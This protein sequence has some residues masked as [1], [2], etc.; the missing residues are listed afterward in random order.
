MIGFYLSLIVISIFIVQKVYVVVFVIA[1]FVLLVSGVR[2]V[3]KQA[4]LIAGVLFFL[5]M[6]SSIVYMLNEDHSELTQLV[7]V[8]VSLAFLPF[9]IGLI[10]DERIE[11]RVYVD[12]LY[13]VLVFALLVNAAH[14]FYNVGKADVW[15]LPFGGEM[16]SSSAY[17]IQ[18]VGI[19][20]GAPN[21]NI[22]ATKFL[23]VFI[24]YI[25]MFV[26]GLR[27]VKAVDVFLFFLFS[28]AVIYGMSRTSQLAYFSFIALLVFD[29]VRRFERY[30]AIVYV[31]LV[32]VFAV[33]INAFINKM[34]HFEF[35]ESDGFFSRTILWA[36][37]LDIEGIKLILGSGPG[38]GGYHIPLYTP[39]VNDNFHNVFVNQLADLG[40]VGLVFYFLMY[41][42]FFSLVRSYLGSVRALIFLLPLLIVVNSHYTGFDNDIFVY[43]IL[44][45]FISR[46][47]FLNRAGAL[48]V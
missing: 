6:W 42:W 38:Y 25:S 47:S 32:P 1:P 41:F 15:M 27:R 29:N 3:S 19:Y 35:D 24:A 2:N 12:A 8:F 20:F 17:K 28:L 23:F 33:L 34:L 18:D 22:W 40:M 48:R 45:I 31:I 26:L 30:R 43:F 9:V 16:T 21:K 11:P 7:K 37:V 44:C 10:L 36:S 46:C 14:I 4:L 5:V 39:L 13:M